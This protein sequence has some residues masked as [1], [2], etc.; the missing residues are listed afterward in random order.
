MEAYDGYENL[1]YCVTRGI[2][3]D[4]VRG[5]LLG[6]TYEGELERPFADR[7]IAGLAELANSD[8]ALLASSYRLPVPAVAVQSSR[9]V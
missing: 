6:I 8:L 5:S 7:S 1:G 9:E 2:I 3:R 4:G